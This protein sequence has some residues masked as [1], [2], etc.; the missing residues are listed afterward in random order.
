MKLHL[1]L[2]APLAACA[3]LLAAPSAHATLIFDN[4]LNSGNLSIETRTAQSMYAAVISTSTDITITEFGAQVR[5][6]ASGNLKFLIFD[7]LSA[8][9][10]GALLFSLTTAVVGTPGPAN[11]GTVGYLY[12]GPMSFTLLAGRR[13]DIGV[14]ADV[15]LTGV[16]DQ[17]VD[18][19][20]GITSYLTNANFSTFAAPVTTGTYGATDPHIQLFSGPAV[21]EPTTALFGA[22]LLGVCGLARRRTRSTPAPA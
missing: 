14:L 10:T 8:G 12:S 7:S 22:A 9:G 19:Q 16:W 13:Y 3:A 15:S 20:N 1:T 21:P 5:A 11:G 2:L 17:A 6:E 4:A 18:S